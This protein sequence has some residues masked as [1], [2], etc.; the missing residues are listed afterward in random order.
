MARIA[1]KHGLT[2]RYREG[3]SKRLVKR[4][5]PRTTILGTTRRKSTSRRSYATAPAQ[6]I[7][8]KKVGSGYLAAVIA[9]IAIIILVIVVASNVNKKP[10]E[11]KQLISLETLCAT[12]HPMLFDEHTTIKEYYKSFANFCV[13][14]P[15]NNGKTDDAVLVAHKSHNN[16]N[17]RKLTFNFSALSN[18]EKREL[19]LNKVLNISLNYVPIDLILEYFIFDKAI[20]ASRDGYT[21]YELYYRENEE[22]KNNMTG[23]VYGKLRDQH[24][25]SVVVKEYDN[26]NYIVELDSLW[27]DFAYDTNP[28]VGQPVSEEELATHQEWAFSLKEYEG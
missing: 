21:S 7:P 16:D 3:G 12:D 22:A 27:Y 17:I 19:T 28:I 11:E 24:G 10:A 9:V 23:E 6:N 2:N 18:E 15:G 20:Q 4:G 5:R 26:G 1:D 8:V 14:S 13:N 25:F